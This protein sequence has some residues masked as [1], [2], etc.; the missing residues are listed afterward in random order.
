LRIGGLSS[1]KVNSP[2]LHSTDPS[3][4]EPFPD[5]L[6]EIEDEDATWINLTK[7]AAIAE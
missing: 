6:A 4:R 3:K 1:K 7:N 5:R 2:A